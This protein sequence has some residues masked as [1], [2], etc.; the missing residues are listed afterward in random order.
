M[1]LVHLSWRH[2]TER[3][4]TNMSQDPSALCWHSGTL[5]RDSATL[6]VSAHRER[7]GEYTPTVLP[8]DC[9]CS[10]YWGQKTQRM[11]MLS[12]LLPPGLAPG[13]CPSLCGA[14]V[15]SV[16]AHWASCG[17]LSAPTPTPHSSTY[18]TA[19]MV[20]LQGCLPHQTQDS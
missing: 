13:V 20:C 1:H 2:A 9:H 3:S 19:V 18:H 10:P 17:S 8:P 12:P 7:R 6:V 5:G 4:S 11:L 16:S 14:G 15:E